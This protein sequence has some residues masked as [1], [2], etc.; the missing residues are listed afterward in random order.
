MSKSYPFAFSYQ[1]GGKN[2]KKIYTINSLKIFFST[3]YALILFDMDI[4]L[5]ERDG[6]ALSAKRGIYIL[7][8]GE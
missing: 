8:K 4:D 1:S 7:V 6:D 5:V 2:R 3:G